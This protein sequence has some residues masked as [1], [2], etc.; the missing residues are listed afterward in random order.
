MVLKTLQIKDMDLNRRYSFNPSDISPKLVKQAID[1]RELQRRNSL[2][3][4]DFAKAKPTEHK[5]WHFISG[6]KASEAIHTCNSVATQKLRES[7]WFKADEER[8]FCAVIE[9]GFIVEVTNG[10]STDNSKNWYGI[11][12]VEAKKS[13]YIVK[14]C[15]FYF[16]NFDFMWENL[17]I[18]FELEIF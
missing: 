9:S 10:H 3:A 1:I 13:E 2:N 18:S 14:M 12:S 6:T 16:L 7:K 5:W 17:D 11:V 15:F 4:A 8:L